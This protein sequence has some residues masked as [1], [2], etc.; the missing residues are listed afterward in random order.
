MR[1]QFSVQDTVPRI[2]VL[3]TVGISVVSRWFKTSSQSGILGFSGASTA[4]KRML[5]F[6]VARVLLKQIHT[7]LCE[8]RVRSYGHT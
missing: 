4:D 8:L 7:R 6:L 3:L 1:V 5:S 2:V